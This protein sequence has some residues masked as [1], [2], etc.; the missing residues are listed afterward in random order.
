MTKLPFLT[1]PDL[2]LQEKNN[3]PRKDY[4][5]NSYT[6]SGVAWLLNFFLESDVLVYRGK[7]IEDTW[8]FDGKKYRL[9]E[10]QEV[11]KQ[12]CP[13]LAEKEEFEFKKNIAI[14]WMHEFPRKKLLKEKII[15]LTRD[16]RDTIYSQ[17]KREN[18]F[19][20]FNK[21]LSSGTEPFNLNP[22]DTW[23]LM[24]HDWLTAIKK[25]NL[26]IIKFKEIKSNPFPV[27]QKLLVFLNIDLTEEEINRGIESSGFERAKR[28]EE[29][30]RK[31]GGKTQ[32]KLVNR[33]GVSGEWR[34][35][36]MSKELSYFKGFPNS[37]LK[38]LNYDVV[39]EDSYPRTYILKMGLLVCLF[40]I[41]KFCFWQMKRTII[42]L[43]KIFSKMNI[44]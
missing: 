25:E 2:G 13:V 3:M 4:L 6:G 37:I 34:D 26:F 20:D 16:G 14:R 21:M 40:K 42:L 19:K 28:A 30:Y 22:A 31:K 15:L 1:K 12:W 43:K 9:R 41:K 24:N 33:K 27:L 10:D 38:K 7:S 5:I 23:A 39:D 11:L 36:Y 29:E 18:I 8:D 32:F 44:C 35:I 17:F